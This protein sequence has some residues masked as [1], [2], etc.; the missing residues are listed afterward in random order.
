MRLGLVLFAQELLIAFAILLALT[1]AIDP[2]VDLR[3]Q[4]S[5]TG[6]EIV[7][8]GLPFD[9]RDQLQELCPGLIQVVAGHFLLSLEN[10]LGALG[11]RHGDLPV[12][13]TL[14]SDVR[15]E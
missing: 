14:V 15:H 11:G 3:E 5:R 10:H 9:S 2:A 13:P 12:H 6:M 8:P 1:I 7:Q 4:T